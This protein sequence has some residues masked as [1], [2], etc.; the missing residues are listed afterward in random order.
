MTTTINASTVSGLVQTADTS[1]VLALQT[2]NTTALTVDG[3][4]NIGIG[5]TSPATKFHVNGSVATPILAQSSLSTVY[6]Q[7][8][9]SGGSAYVG[10]TGN[11]L[12]FLVNA[13]GNEAMRIDSSG[14]VGIG[15]TSP[16]YKMDVNVG[17][18]GGAIRAYNT[19]NT[20]T[21]YLRAT[22]SQSSV[23]MG[24]DGTGG[25]VEQIGAYP[26]R[27]FANNIEAARINSSGN[28]LVGTTSDTPN[29]QTAGYLTFGNIGGKYG[30]NA[31]TDSSSDRTIIRFSNT[32]GN[33]GGINTNGMSTAYNT[34]S[35]YRLKENVA[36]MTG[37]LAKVAQLK[38]S[39]YKWKADGS[40]GEGF[41]AHELAEVCP[42]AVSGTKDEVDAD[43]NPQYQGID[44]SFLVA[45]L[46][47][48]IQEAKALIDTQAETINALTAR[49][50][51]LESK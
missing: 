14:N 6:S 21:A 49:I 47:A 40:D 39:T 35:D 34:S 38:P 36:P 9:N 19:A 48:A 12:Q 29:S 4:Q 15:T 11:A 16:S 13:A 20:N 1:G 28:L 42:H 10:S 7:Y 33:V 26:L 23:Q 50:V 17:S 41:I 45:T 32:N 25:F 3:S 8:Q 30:A 2:A 24:E 51:A 44:V 18:S 37:A 22:N 43:G 5:T 31:F 27:F 46:T